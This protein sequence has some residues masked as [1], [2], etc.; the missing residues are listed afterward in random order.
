RRR[1]RAPLLPRL[2]R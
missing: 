2:L 1:A